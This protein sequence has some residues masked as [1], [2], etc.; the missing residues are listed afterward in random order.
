MP[1]KKLRV[2]KSKFSDDKDR[3]DY[4]LTE[5]LKE[6]CELRILVA[7]LK[8][9]STEFPTIKFSEMAEKLQ[10]IINS[11]ASLPQ[12]KDITCCS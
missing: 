5:W 7:A 2:I 8:S 1:Y 11:K 9:L 3:F 12:V 10:G 4:V 6:N